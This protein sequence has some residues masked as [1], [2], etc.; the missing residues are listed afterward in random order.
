MI[1][2]AKRRC[3]FLRTDEMRIHGDEAVKYP[4]RLAADVVLLI[5][6][7]KRGF[8]M[9]F[10]YSYRRSIT[11]ASRFRAGDYAYHPQLF[12]SSK[13][14]SAIVKDSQALGNRGGI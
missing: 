13:D 7:V 1:I 4:L 9:S 14:L 8:I 3:T 6:D 2:E 5:R 11:K 12:L 10:L